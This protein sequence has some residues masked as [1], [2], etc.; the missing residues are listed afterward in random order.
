MT[1]ILLQVSHH[2]KKIEICTTQRTMNST[3]LDIKR[4]ILCHDDR[5]WVAATE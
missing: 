5:R 1:I 2:G 4:R 3:V